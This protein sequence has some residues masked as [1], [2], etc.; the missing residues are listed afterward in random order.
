M[1]RTSGSHGSAPRSM[2]AAVLRDGRIE[3]Q[4]RTTPA[5][6]RGEALLRPRLSGVCGTDLEL[7]RGYQDF[8][9]V[10]GHEFVADI[11]R[12]PDQENLEGKRAVADI[13][14]GCGECIECLCRGQAHCP[15]RSVIGIRGEQGAFAEY[16]TVPAANLHILPRDMPDRLA[17]FAEPLAAA[18]RPTQQILITADMHVAVLGDG[19]M[20]LL[21]AMALRHVNPEILLVGRHSDKLAI[22]ERT[23]GSTLLTRHE[24]SAALPENGGGGFDLVVEATGN[25]AGIEQAA[26]MCRPQGT[27]ALKTTSQ[28]ATS[29][30]FS[31]IASREQRILGSRCGNLDLAL[32]YLQYGLVNPRPLIET[33]IPWPEVHKALE[34]GAARGS[35]K[36]LLDHLGPAETIRREG[37]GG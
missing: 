18:L 20:G 5:P 24:D 15:H 23:G 35:K 4:E 28:R 2:T 19:K 26:R 36:V 12:V 27:I 14:C 16:L 25:P 7:L 9:G 34:Q 29:F 37:H 30:P 1:S 17:V 3:L 22:F 31:L 6:A 33:V 10:P 32:H 11:V 8:S 21:T 13:N